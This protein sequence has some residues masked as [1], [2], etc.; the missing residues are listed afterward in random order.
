MI[1]VVVVGMVSVRWNMFDIVNEG[2]VNG[3][4]EGGVQIF[5]NGTNNCYVEMNR[6]E[7]ENMID[8]KM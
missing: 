1:K 5:D 3:S 2:S 6:V 7:V 8:M 4:V